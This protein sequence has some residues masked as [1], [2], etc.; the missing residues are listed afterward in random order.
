MN[1]LQIKR[2]TFHSSFISQIEQV[3]VKETV[4]SA[5]EMRIS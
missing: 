4:T 2:I 1:V 5:L 3:Q